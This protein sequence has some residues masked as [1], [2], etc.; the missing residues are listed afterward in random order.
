MIQLT[1]LYGHPRSPEAFD[2][3]YEETHA[4]LAR[5][6]PRLKGFTVTRPASLNPQEPSAYYLIASL[7]FATMDEFQEALRSSEGQAAAEDLANFATG[8]ATLLAGEVHVYEPL[9]IG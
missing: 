5:R 8:G 6:L 2:R 7:Y 1:V 9:V 3:Y 4:P